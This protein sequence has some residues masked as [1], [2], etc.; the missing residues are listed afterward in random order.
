M[1][2]AIK[3]SDFVAFYEQQELPGIGVVLMFS[4][5]PNKAKVTIEDNGLLT[6]KQDD[7]GLDLAISGEFW[8]LKS[9]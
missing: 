9:Q 7:I 6:I 2:K 3:A 8:K 1:A 5:N 4:G